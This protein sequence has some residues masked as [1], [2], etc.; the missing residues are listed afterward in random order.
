MIMLDQK[1]TIAF[2]HLYHVSGIPFLI[3][4]IKGN[5]LQAH[6]PRLKDF[7]RAEYWNAF[8][9]D[10][11]TSEHPD[12]TTLICVGEMYHVAII[13]LD[14]DHFFATVPLSSA[15]SKTQSFFPALQHGIQPDRVVEFYRFL[16]ELPSFSNTRLSETASLAKLLYCGEPAHGTSLMYLGDGGK[17]M[18]EIQLKDNVTVASL[19]YD[20]HTS[21]KH[22][23][24]SYEESVKEAIIAGDEALLNT[25]IRR[26]VYGAIGRMSLNDLRQARYEFICIMYACCRAAIQGGLAPE[27]SYQLSDLFCQRMDGMTRA[28]EIGLY[29]RECM[30]QFCRKVAENKHTASYSSYTV[31]CC[32][33]IRQHLLE[34]MDVDIISH[35]VGLNRRSLARYFIEDT[36]MTISEYITE[37][38]LEEGAHLLT[39]SE[40]SLSDISH[41]LQFS[42]QSQF[43]QKFRD[44]YK[45]TP[46]QHRKGH[47]HKTDT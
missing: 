36:G 15:Q 9:G 38:R 21:M 42:S 26:P 7:Y 14:K 27:Y 11:S 35:A 41:L 25:V 39:N 40:L 20:D 24:S 22:I 19:T 32:E 43:T 3:A 31:A 17:P 33:Y 5:V 28:D 2:E 44:K 18:R 4:D 10:L 29:S 37:K 6:P 1:K 46:A 13:K 34:P 45:T 12:G 23:S 47:H 16:S 8:P 30:R